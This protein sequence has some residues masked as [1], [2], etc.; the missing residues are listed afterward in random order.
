MN[1]NSRQ[2]TVVYLFL[3]GGLK[4][5]IV[6]LCFVLICIRVANVSRDCCR[7]RVAPR[8]EHN[9]RLAIIASQ[10]ALLKRCAAKNGIIEQINF[11]PR[12]SELEI[13]YKPGSPGQAALNIS[14][15]LISPGLNLKPPEA[16][17]FPR[18]HLASGVLPTSNFSSAADTRN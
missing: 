9:A 3:D 14:R 2:G 7:V 18:T 1:K 8:P 6:V 13:K 10:N 5:R 11:L 16:E 4:D 12:R 15:H 17:R